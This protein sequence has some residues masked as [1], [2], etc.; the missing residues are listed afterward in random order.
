[1]EEYKDCDAYAANRGVMIPPYAQLERGGIVGIANLVGCVQQ[2]PSPWF[3]GPYGWVMQDARPIEF[4]PC[5]GELK[6]FSPSD[7]VQEMVRRA[8]QIG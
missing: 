7:E 3:A 6:L 8:V 1:M 5:P 4:I 2:H